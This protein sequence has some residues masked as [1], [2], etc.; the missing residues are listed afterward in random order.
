M[1]QPGN[2]FQ[3]DWAKIATED[4]PVWGYNCADSVAVAACSNAVVV[5]GKSRVSALNLDDG[6]ALWSEAVPSA[7]VPWGMAVDR[8][9]RVV[10]ALEDGQVVCFG[11]NPFASNRTGPR[12]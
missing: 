7:P 1:T 11:Q 10:V 4:K 6:A 8:D 9:G 12:P 5:A 3:V 2:R